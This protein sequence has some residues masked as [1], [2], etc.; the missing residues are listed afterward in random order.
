MEEGALVLIFSKTMTRHRLN[1]MRDVDFAMSG[2]RAFWGQE[3][4]VQRPWVSGCLMCLRNK[5]ELG[6]AE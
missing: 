1:V 5:E 6:I 3:Q 4:H 2:A